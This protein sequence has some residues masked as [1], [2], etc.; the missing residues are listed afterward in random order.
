MKQELLPI[1][2][3]PEKYAAHFSLGFGLWMDHDWRKHGWDTK[4]F[5]KN[6]YSPKAFE[7]SVRTA[8]H[9]ADEYVWVY[10][11]QPRWWSKD[12]MQVKLPKEYSDAVNAAKSE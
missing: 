5:S 3:A 8:L 7:Q 11:E 1:V 12:R 9:T 6:Y 2:G 10:T 4:D